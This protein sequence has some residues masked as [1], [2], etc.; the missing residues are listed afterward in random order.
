MESQQKSRAEIIQQ[1]S[2]LIQ[3]IDFAMLTTVDEEG[4]LR[5]RPMSTQKTTRSSTCPVDVPWRPC[6]DSGRTTESAR[7]AG[8]ARLRLRPKD[9][10]D[11]WNLTWVI[12]A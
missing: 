3:D 8:R 4:T 1:L 10:A 6:Y 12:P 5:S 9:A 2:E 11:P 7:G